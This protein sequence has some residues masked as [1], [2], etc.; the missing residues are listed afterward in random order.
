MRSLPIIAVFLCQLQ[1]DSAATSQGAARGDVAGT[2]Q[3]PVPWSQFD[4]ELRTRDPWP[5][6]TP[7]AIR[8][9]GMRAEGPIF[10]YG[11]HIVWAG[12]DHSIGWW[13]QGAGRQLNFGRHF[14]RDVDLT[15]EVF[16]Y[17]ALTL[18][19]ALKSDCIAHR[20]I[21]VPVRVGKDSAEV[22]NGVVSAEMDAALREALAP[23]LL[24]QGN[25]CQVIF[26][27]HKTA[28][29]LFDGCAIAFQFEVLSGTDVIARGEEL[30]KGGTTGDLA[31]R[32]RGLS[33]D[34]FR[35]G[36]VKP[37]EQLRIH[38]TSDPQLALQVLEAD[39]YWKGELTLDVANIMDIPSF[40][41]RP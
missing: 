3:T 12:T 29:P 38:L 40:R 28:S 24:R 21:T 23:D 22:M 2:E 10:E 25:D 26:Q 32:G 20:T 1:T 5:R 17:R 19:D 15:F 36:A 31:Y 16:L 4:V 11:A 14:D 13:V 37:T 39:K 7:L 6:D 9:I 27:A 33:G 35:L 18:P 8:A 41:K 34:L 30:W